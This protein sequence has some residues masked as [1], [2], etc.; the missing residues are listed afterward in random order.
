MVKHLPNMCEAYLG[1]NLWHYKMKVFLKKITTNTNRWLSDLGP[2]N[3]SS[4]CG[5]YTAEE[6]SNSMNLS[7]DFHHDKCNFNYHLVMLLN[8]F[9]MPKKLMSGLIACL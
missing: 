8:L 2:D 3:F 4:I 9:T 1:F 5:T 6:E 7:S